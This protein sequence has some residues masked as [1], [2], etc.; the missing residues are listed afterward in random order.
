MKD[1]KNILYRVSIESVI[2]NTDRLIVALQYDSRIVGQDDVFVAIKG[3]AFDGH[4]FISKAIEQGVSV[5]V[6][7][8]LPV[9]LIKGITYV[10][11]GNTSKSLA[12]MASNYYESPSKNLKLVGITGTNGKTTIATLLYEL[13]KN[14]GY[15]VG[16]ISTCLLYT[17]P[18]PRDS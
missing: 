16:L 11:V 3:S 13:F 10:V 2:G 12:I 15:K 9:K 17:S 6:C 5:V 8:N 14:A 4:E 1:L 18:S 7:E